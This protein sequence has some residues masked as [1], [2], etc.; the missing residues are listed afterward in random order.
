MV[1]DGAKRHRLLIGLEATKQA[2]P[3]EPNM[4]SKPRFCPECEFFEPAR[5]KFDQIATRLQSM[6]P[7]TFAQTEEFIRIESLELQRCLLQARLDVLFQRERAH[8]LANPPPEGVKK[9][10]RKQQIES[11]FGRVVERRHALKEVGKRS[12]FP[13]D[14]QLNVPADLYSFPLRRRV[15]EE[16]SRGS[17]DAAVKQIERTTAGHVPKRQAEQL[18]A[19]AAKDMTAFYDEGL[20][21]QASND[22]LSDRAVL[23]L[24]SDGCAIRMVPDG[25]R[26]PT[27][28]AAEKAEQAPNAAVHG[29]PTAKEPIKPHQ[30]RRAMVTA[31]WEQERHERTAEDVLANLQRDPKDGSQQDKA[32]GPRPQH[33][34]I[35]A[36]IEQ[37]LRE[38]VN[39]MFN[40]ADRRDPLCLRETVVLVD[41]DEH[42]TQ[43]IK[44][45]GQRRQR[46]LTLVLDLL[47]AMHYLWVIAIIM[48]AHCGKLQRQKAA[49]LVT[50]WVGIL[51][52]GDPARAIAAIRAMATRLKL[53]GEAR[54]SVDKAAN[55]LLKRSPHIRYADFIARGLPIASGVIEGACRHIVRDRLDITG[56]RWNVKVAEAVLAIRA[57]RSSGDWD[58]YWEFHQRKEAERNYPYA[59]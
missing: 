22:T 20:R 16:A 37:D 33:K 9:R 59:A 39:E 43:A 38:R 46:P 2:K 57:L 29:D 18:A 7:D 26:E 25:L 27:R 44:E 23:A 34:R 54:K 28:Q 36:S 56:A 32:R 13:L 8:F 47:H 3:K 6:D 5:R 12:Q 52:T 19:C 30:T 45:E 42:Q 53:R 21:Q 14:E 17:F 24:S 48:T 50:S 15:A 49:D 58:D 1:N 31:V 4:G 10:V 40:E 51:L 55:Y 35:T 41:G 11:Q